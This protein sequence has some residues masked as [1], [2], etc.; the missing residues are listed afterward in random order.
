[1]HIGDLGRNIENKRN[2]LQEEQ[3]HDQFEYHLVGVLV[4]SGSADSGHYYSYIKERNPRSPHF[5]KWFEFNDTTVREFDLKNL[6]AEC[7]GGQQNTTKEQDFERE[8]LTTTQMF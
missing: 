1:V 3:K 5:G 6:R 7:F 4:H 2:L 8:P